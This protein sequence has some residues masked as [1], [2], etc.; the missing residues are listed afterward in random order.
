MHC[1][2]KSWMLWWLDEDL[3]HL[4]Q[5]WIQ[6]HDSLPLKDIYLFW[7]EKALLKFKTEENKNMSQNWS[8]HMFLFPSNHLLPIHTTGTAE[9]VSGEQTEICT[10][11]AEPSDEPSLWN[12]VW[13]T[14]HWDQ[15]SEGRHDFCREQVAHTPENLFFLLFSNLKFSPWSFRVPIFMKRYVCLHEMGQGCNQME[16]DVGR[17][18]GRELLGTGWRGPATLVQRR[19]AMGTSGEGCQCLPSNTGVDTCWP[20]TLWLRSSVGRWGPRLQKWCFLGENRVVTGEEKA[21][22]GSEQMKRR[23]QA[24]KCVAKPCAYNVL[25]K[26]IRVH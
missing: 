17:L 4:I 18:K 7:G 9:E 25:C 10:S 16:K 23:F 13:R 26:V 5:E 21:E 6:I 2:F 3:A 19:K 12:I 22:R 8:S 15:Q 1:C 11:L 20:P 24:W 14:S